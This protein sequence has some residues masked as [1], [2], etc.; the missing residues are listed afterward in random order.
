MVTTP[1]YCRLFN[2]LPEGVQDGL[3]EQPVFPV[4]MRDSRQ[5][6]VTNLYFVQSGIEK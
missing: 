1:R 4:K 5:T 2:T 3:K 6:I